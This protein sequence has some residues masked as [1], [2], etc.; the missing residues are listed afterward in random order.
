MRKLS[1]CAVLT[2]LF[3]LLG[4]CMYPNELRK[5]NQVPPGE[6]I[7]LVQNAVDTFREKTGVLPIKNSEMDTP[8]YEKYVIDF[9]K[10]QERR[11]LGTIPANAFE[12]GGSYLYVLINPETKPEVKLMD[13]AAFQQ[14]VDLQKKV[15]DYQN[16]HNGELPSGEQ[17]AEHFYWIDYGKLNMKVQQV[18]S[19]YSRQLL[20]FIMSD[21]GDVAIDYGPELTAL[22]QKKTLAPD[23]KED[24]RA[25]LVKES[26]FVPVRSYPYYFLHNEPVITLRQL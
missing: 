4:G 18:K 23:P 10:L 20:N 9:K 22:L 6:Y 21:K 2:G 3:L 11:L 19:V 15:Q 26:Y 8:I 13:L 25:L 16:S 17:A 24:L 7:L 5:E 12:R 1:L 14:T